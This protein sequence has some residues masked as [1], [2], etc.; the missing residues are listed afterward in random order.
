[1]TTFTVLPDETILFRAV[2]EKSWKTKDGKLKWQTFKRMKKDVDGVS[3]FTTPEAA[4]ENLSRPFFGM[5]SVLVGNV[6]KISTDTDTLDVIQD[7]ENHANITGIPYIYDK[8]ENEQDALNA[9]MIRLCRL[10]AEN[11]AKLIADK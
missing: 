5:A 1:M 6:R 7:G 9:R 4:Q 11:A 10:I 8:P 3:V 2:L